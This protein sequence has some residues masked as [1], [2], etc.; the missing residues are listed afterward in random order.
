MALFET[1]GQYPHPDH[2]ERI[3]KY[4]RMEKIFD[5]KLYEVYERATDLLKNTPHA[6]QLKNL[7]I[8]V[9]LA[10]IIVTKPADLIVGEVPQFD[11]DEP[12]D[13]EVEKALNRIVE[14]NDLVKQIHEAVIG[15]GIRGDAWFKVRYGYDQDFASLEEIGLPVPDDAEMMPII[16]TVPAEYVFPELARGS[17]KKFSAI[18]IAWVEWVKEGEKEVPYLNVERHLPGYI[19]YKRFRVYEAG[20]DTRFGVEIQ[21]YRI[22]EEVPTGREEDIEETGTTYFLVHHFPYKTKDSD[23][24]GIGGLEKLESVLAAIN[25]R[26]VQIDYILW[27]HSDPTAYG[28]SLD[29][30]GNR[31]AASWGGR[32]IVVSKEDPTPGY[33]TWNAQLD[34]AFKELDYLLGI[35]YQLSETPQWLFGTTISQDK[36]GT[37]TSH[38]DSVAIKLRMMPILSKVKRIRTHLDR[39]IRDAIYT[40]MQV[41][42]F[43]NEGVEGFE[44]Y[45]PKYPTVKWKDGVPRDE[46]ELAQI[47][48]IRTGN[49]PTLDVHS[50][51]KILDEVDD[52]RASE[53]IRR[54][55]EDEQRTLGTVD[56]SIFNRDEEVSA[57]EGGGN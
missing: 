12:D 36:G 10:D 25:D 41:E 22:G 37:G 40:A 54:I 32:Y 38:T 57:N 14:E 53:I 29:E 8:A 21:L 45:E 49:K 20:V 56:P 7:Y 2:I 15:A 28:P 6:E 18:N 52:A 44:P 39:A 46:K 26:L 34:G 50:A 35:V 5:G 51:I 31:S 4:K 47:M 13:S 17:N 3:A 48:Q 19:V 16:E 9:N 33:M 27:K 1:D 30:E 23:W 43:A 24:A 55:D 11:T 42:N